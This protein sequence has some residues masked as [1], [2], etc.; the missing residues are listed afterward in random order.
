MTPLLDP[1]KLVTVNDAQLEPGDVVLVNHPGFA[2]LAVICGL[3]PSNRL[4]TLFALRNDNSALIAGRLGDLFE[5]GGHLRVLKKPKLYLRIGPT[6]Y[7]EPS[8]V[9]KAA[10]MLGIDAIGPF[11][12]S[13]TN[14]SKTQTTAVS[15]SDYIRERD[16]DRDR[17][18]NAWSWFTHWQLQ[19]VDE[20]GNETEIIGHGDRIKRDG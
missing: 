6:F 12:I 16:G 11:A 15:L 10:G 7:V 20:F 17:F 4:S 18:V 9:D 3:H 19:Y 8:E 14:T 13:Y 1:A 5:R 2:G